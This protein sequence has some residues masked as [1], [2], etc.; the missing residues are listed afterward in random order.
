MDEGIYIVYN[1]D[2]EKAMILADYL[3]DHGIPVD[4]DP[5]KKS[6]KN[7]MKQ[8]KRSGLRFVFVMDNDV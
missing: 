8:A 1:N 3:R 4:F 5:V 7:Q 6:Y 2:L